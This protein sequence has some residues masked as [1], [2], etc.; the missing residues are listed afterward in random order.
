MKV[1]RHFRSGIGGLVALIC[2]LGFA[3][4]TIAAQLDEATVTQIVRQ[5]DLLPTGAAA[6]AAALNDNVRGGTAV[7]SGVDSR[8]GVPG[9][10]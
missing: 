3:R 1:R 7:R 10:P 6:R 9:G 5:V 8:L 4:S 2:A